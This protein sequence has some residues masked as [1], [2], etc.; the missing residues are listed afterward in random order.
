V[1]RIGT[2]ALTE[3]FVIRSF[4]KMRASA[5]GAGFEGSY[6]RVDGLMKVSKRCRS[7]IGRHPDYPHT[8]VRKSL[9]NRIN[10]LF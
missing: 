3:A 7:T 5:G 6:T 10:L 2:T 8:R 9:R 1:T 4:Y